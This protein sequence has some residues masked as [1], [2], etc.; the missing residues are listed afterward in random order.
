MK[1]IWSV[2]IIVLLLCGC[3]PQN[4]A[5]ERAITL[6]SRL[7]SSAGCAFEAN[8]NADYGEKIYTFTLDCISDSYGNIQFVVTSP[9][10]IAGISGEISHNGGTLTFDNQSLAFELLAD[11]CASPVSAPWLLMRALLGGYISSCAVNEDGLVMQ[12][13][14]SYEEDPLKLEVWTDQEL[15]PNR[16]DI[17]W[18][19]RRILA[20]EIE[21]FSFINVQ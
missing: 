16:A 21:D 7:Q 1:R 10:S 19:G 20:V 17:L 18:Q 9:E 8:I 2:A 14:D 12:I 11:G 3:S 4:T 15:Y 6:R 13:D 5:Y